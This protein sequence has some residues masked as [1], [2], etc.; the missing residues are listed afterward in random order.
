[1]RLARLTISKRRAAALML[2]LGALIVYA[3][4]LESVADAVE[5]ALF[6]SR[7]TEK[8]ATLNLLCDEV[9]RYVEAD[10]DWG[11]Y[12]YSGD[13]GVMV[14]ELDSWL[15][16]YAALMDEGLNTISERLY[17][18]GEEP[19][20]PARNPSFQEAVRELDSGEMYVPSIRL[21]GKPGEMRLYFRWIPTGNG[22][23]E[24]LL[25][26]IAMSRDALDSS[27]VGELI[28]WC[29]GLICAASAVIVAAV[30][31]TMPSRGK[32]AAHG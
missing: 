11:E 22:Y 25:A 3:M 2:A 5:D 15:G 21:D 9:D 30:A 17:A 32:A 16:V 18:Q 27:P 1:M 31:L 12:D 24:R 20:E 19:L 6:R 28:G 7:W 10:D 14:R 23:S 26:V 29:V 4:R 13:M 8:K